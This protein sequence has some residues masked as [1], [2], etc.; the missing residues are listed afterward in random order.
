MEADEAAIRKMWVGLSIEDRAW[1]SAL[2][3]ILSRSDMSIFLKD[4]QLLHELMP[5]RDLS[6]S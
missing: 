2:V 3:K 5:D 4:S 1:I 6:N